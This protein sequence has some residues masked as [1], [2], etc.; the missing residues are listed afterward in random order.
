MKKTKLIFTVLFSFVI[1]LLSGCLPSSYYEDWEEIEGYAVT[2]TVKNARTDTEAHQLDSFEITN[3]I[4]DG[5]NIAVLY[6]HVLGSSSNPYCR[7]IISELTTDAS[8]DLVDEYYPIND[9]SFYISQ[10]P[11]FIFDGLILYVDENNCYVINDLYKYNFRDHYGTY[12][13]ADYHIEISINGM[14][15]LHFYMNHVESS[16]P[17][18]KR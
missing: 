16:N 3:D 11:K 12:Q 1:I 5:Q 15:N 17:L 2:Q 18:K 6:K 7:V 9:A 14:K 10:N 4:P 13:K 8:K